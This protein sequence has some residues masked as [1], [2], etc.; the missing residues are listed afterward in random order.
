[1]IEI[2]TIVVVPISLN[3]ASENKY[4]SNDYVCELFSSLLESMIAPAIVKLRNRLTSGASI[5]TRPFRWI[6]VSDQ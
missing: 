6:L 5:I 1:M 3:R 4:L 2:G